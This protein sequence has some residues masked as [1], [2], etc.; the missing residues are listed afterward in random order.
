MN[1][2]SKLFLVLMA[3]IMLLVGCNNGMEF[4]EPGDQYTPEDLIALEGENLD[5]D[6]S[7]SRDLLPTNPKTATKLLIDYL[8]SSKGYVRDISGNGKSGSYIYVGGDSSVL[9]NSQATGYGMRL[10]IYG[11]KS[12]SSSSV[13]AAKYRNGFKIIFNKLWKLQHSFPSN[14]YVSNG[15]HSWTIPSSLN[16]RDGQSSG[17]GGELDMAY[18]LIQAH[19]LWGSNG[20]INYRLEA[21]NLVI[22]ITK[23]LYATANVN[24]RSL[25]YLKVG[26]WARGGTEKGYHSRPADWM[27]HHLRT[28]IK[29][30]ETE[31][32]GTYFTL[33]KLRNLLEST[34]YLID[35]NP[36]GK[37][38]FPDYVYFG[39]G[40][41][42]LATTN[43]VNMMNEPIS[44][45]RYSWNSCRTPF[46]LA[47]DAN[48]EGIRNSRIMTNALQDMYR[49]TLMGKNAS[50]TGSE[51]YLNGNIANSKFESA[52]AG[53]IATT[54][55]GRMASIGSAG[56]G[57]FLSRKKKKQMDIIS[58]QFVGA[59]QKGYFGD[60]IITLSMIILENKDKVIKGPYN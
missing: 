6:V 41:V 24:G 48:Q 10:A 51:Y 50:D 11:W 29:F 3:T 45:H 56:E 58:S 34:E 38:L 57:Q 4:N 28:F 12:G 47:M 35:L 23:H 39:N 27:P 53:P 21:Q 7:N 2:E 9:T 17:V 30:F 14:Y 54:M 22:A 59:S 52:F 37:G 44:S 13:G 16:P 42:D 36:W 40:R 1:K 15:L 55:V 26:D 19:K 8:R 32:Q 5:L 31:A 43:F 18:A 60:A 46:R 49:A 33:P 20:E 25:A